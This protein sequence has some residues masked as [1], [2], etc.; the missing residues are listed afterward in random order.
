MH[1]LRTL[2]ILL[3]VLLLGVP[4]AHGQST[5][6]RARELNASIF[7]A[8]GANDYAQAEALLRELIPLDEANFVHRYNLACALSMQGKLEPAGK[9]LQKAVILGFSDKQQMESDPHLRP[10]RETEDYLVVVEGWDRFMEARVDARIEQAAQV[11]GNRYTTERDNDLRLAYVSAF[12][13]TTFDR[14]KDEIDRLAE[15]WVRHVL[16]EGESWMGRPGPDGEEFEPPWVLVLLPTRED[17]ARWAIPHYGAA[18]IRI[19][20]VYSND[21]KELVSLGLGSSLRHEFWHVLHWRHQNKL[22]QRHP[23][24]IMEGLCSLVED[25]EVGPDGEMIAMP[26]WRTNMIKRLSRRGRPMPLEQMFTLSHTQFVKQRPLANYAQSRALFVWLAQRGLLKRWYALY[27][28]NYSDDHTGRLAFEMTFDEPLEQ[29]EAH[30][31]AWL[32][33]IDE[34]PEDLKRGMTGFPFKVTPSPDADGIRIT[35]TVSATSARDSGLKMRDVILTVD[36][37]PVRDM[38]DLIRVMLAKQPGDR[39]EIEYRRGRDNYATTTIEL[40]KLTR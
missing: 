20:G 3:A 2:P 28:Q 24:W 6:Q 4:T 22:R 9:E 32:R 7:R 26:S 5:S 17:Y 18:W 36:A 31:R 33:E 40:V 13:E 30:F 27:T 37:E 16:P 25:V 14:A 39:V 34:V 11:Y 35:T 10:I 29:V 23:I 19:G 12:D 21:R 8:F 1:L 38:N 15:W